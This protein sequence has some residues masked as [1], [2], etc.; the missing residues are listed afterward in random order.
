MND[1]L[2]LGSMKPITDLTVR[3]DILGCLVCLS[4]FFIKICTLKRLCRI[5]CCGQQYEYCLRRATF[6]FFSVKHS[7]YFL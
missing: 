4:I 7:V 5:G 6:A 1:D 2:L 3:F